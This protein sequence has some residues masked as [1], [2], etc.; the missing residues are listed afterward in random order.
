MWRAIFATGVLLR[1]SLAEE[2]TTE[3]PKATEAQLAEFKQDF[4]DVDYNKDDQMD[5]MEVRAHFK[6]GIGSLELYHFFND[7]DTDKNGAI[8]LPEYITY[9][10]TLNQS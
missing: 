7:C 1:W 5:A 3:K 10:S 8:S 6:G 9:A 4:L 2:S